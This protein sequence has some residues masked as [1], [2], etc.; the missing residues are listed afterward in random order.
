MKHFL[1]ESAIWQTSSEFVTPEGIISKGEGQ[2]II[3]IYE[4]EI[5]NESWAQLEDIRRTNNYRI[6][7]VSSTEYVFE[8]LNP[9]LGKQTGVF[10]VDRNVLFSKFKI[11]E[12]SLNG[13]EIIRR[14]ED[15]CYVQGALYKNDLLINTWF[16]TM[17]KKLS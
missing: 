5:I 11:E 12:T 8:S 17:T 4:N 7:P 9:E 1:S 6:I 3:S 2:S 10:N 13:F 14:E 15:I 16:A